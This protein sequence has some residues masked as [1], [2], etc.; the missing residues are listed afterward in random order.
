M[1]I[2]ARRARRSRRLTR[3]AEKFGIGRRYMR[4]LEEYQ[5]WL[6]RVGAR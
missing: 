2:Q 5:C 1:S 4:E 6:D 3:I